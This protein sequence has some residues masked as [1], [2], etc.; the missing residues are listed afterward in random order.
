[1]NF[2]VHLNDELVKQLAETAKA[3]GKTRNA[4]IREAVSEWLE[5]QRSKKWSRRIME[6]RGIRGSIR[7]EHTRK[8]LKPPREPFDALST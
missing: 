3:R 7:F 1:M 6:F 5:R 4:V 2:S 8:D